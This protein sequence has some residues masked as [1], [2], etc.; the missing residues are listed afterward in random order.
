M[1]AL[2]VLACLLL[3]TGVTMVTAAKKIVKRYSLD[4]K[5]AIDHGSG[6]DEKETEEY[7]TLR[8]TLNVKLCGMLV[9]LPGLILLLIVLNNM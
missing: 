4:K 6:M 9:F 2:L 8:A 1:P 7:K 5:V 3:V